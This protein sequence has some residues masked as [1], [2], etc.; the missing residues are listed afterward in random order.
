[1]TDERFP[2]PASVNPLM[3]PVSYDGETYYT[4]QYFH[5]QYL[6]GHSETPN[7]YTR[8]PDFAR[9][10]RS[11]EAYSLYVEAGDILELVYQK[12]EDNSRKQI[13]LSLWKSVAYNPLT[14]LNATAQLALS[15]HLDDELSKQMSVAVNKKVARESQ[16]HVSL[17]RQAEDDMG[18]WIRLAALL[19]APRY[20]ALIEGAKDIQ[21]RLGVDL[22]PMLQLSATLDAIP[23]EQTM[24]EPTE[25]GKRLGMSGRDLNRRLEHAGVQARVGGEWW[26]RIRAKSIA[27]ATHGRSERRAALISNGMPASSKRCFSAQSREGRPGRGRPRPGVL[28][29][30]GHPA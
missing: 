25:L 27:T 19:E 20:I 29:A 28:C 22:S 12:V 2:A 26:P 13:L 23:D 5:A 17:L 4:S 14:L 6:A 18:T 11:I 10:L 30:L 7:K 21:K 3:Q 15:H 1:M 8:H 16:D 24:L 9:L